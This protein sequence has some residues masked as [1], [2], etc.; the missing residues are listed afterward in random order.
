MAYN[1]NSYNIIKG[2][3]KRLFLI[4]KLTSLCVSQDTLEMAHKGLV[5]SILQFNI[6][7]RWML[8]GR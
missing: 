6:T 4:R 3:N 1:E 7:A 5:E 2:A 8:Q